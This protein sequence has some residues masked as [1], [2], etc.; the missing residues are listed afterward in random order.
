MI[1]DQSLK[2]MAQIE[3]MKREQRPDAPY[4]VQ[5]Q[6]HAKMCEIIRKHLIEIGTTGPWTMSEGD[7]TYVSEQGAPWVGIVCR[8]VITFALNGYIGLPTGHKHWGKPYTEIEDDIEAH[9]G[10]TYASNGQ[11]LITSVK[12]PNL[13]WFGFDCAHAHDYM[14]LMPT[15]TDPSRYKT[16]VWVR[17]EIVQ[18]ARKM[19][20]G[21]WKQSTFIDL[22][23][24]I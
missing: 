18:I 10:F 9:G 7:Y 1:P 2:L 17:N 22:L 19:F 11:G 20:Q 6:H 14:P 24:D 12:E 15:G 21:N 5:K 4:E 3:Q 8:N 16:E 23:K 13:W